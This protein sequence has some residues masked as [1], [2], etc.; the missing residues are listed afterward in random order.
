MSG[1]TYCLPT[2]NAKQ[3]RK[4]REAAGMTQAELAAALDFSE[5]H[6]RR[7]EDGD[8]RILSRHVLAIR[9][10][11][12]GTVRAQSGAEGSPTDTK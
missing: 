4:A 5:R 7:F 2:M 6:I 3:L 10:V 12:T 11:L 1:W 9:A 8:A